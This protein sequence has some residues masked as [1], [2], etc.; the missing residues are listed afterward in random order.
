MGMVAMARLTYLGDGNLVEYCTVAEVLYVLN[1]Y[2]NLDRLWGSDILK[3][4]PYEGGV[5][6]PWSFDHKKW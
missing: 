1:W 2:A 5:V 6:E 3:V 4:F